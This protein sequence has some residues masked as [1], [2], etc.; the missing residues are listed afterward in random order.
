VPPLPAEKKR[1]GV[2]Y[3]NVYSRFFPIEYLL[4]GL[5]LPDLD[6][7]LDRLTCRLSFAT[8]RLIE[9]KPWIG[10][11]VHWPEQGTIVRDDY[12]VPRR[13]SSSWVH[14]PMPLRSQ[15]ELDA[16]FERQRLREQQRGK[17]EA[18]AAAKKPK[19]EVNSP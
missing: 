6:I 8:P 2:I 1:P 7:V 10:Q 3:G 11:R 18:A 14:L 9:P 5:E 15:A 17:E 16:F 19:T 4:N 13:F 12:P